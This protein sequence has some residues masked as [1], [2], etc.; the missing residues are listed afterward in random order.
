M[1]EALKVMD[2]ITIEKSP[3]ASE[4][5]AQR[6]APKKKLSRFELSMKEAREGKVKTFKTVDEMF[7]SLGI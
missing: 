1:V 7:Q 3:R 4:S 6:T 2:F 5:A